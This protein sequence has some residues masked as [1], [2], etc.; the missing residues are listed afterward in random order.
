VSKVRKGD[1]KEER[2]GVL[3]R[4][5][6]DFNKAQGRFGEAITAQRLETDKENRI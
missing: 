5:E 6:K 2:E 3:R 4:I 1:E